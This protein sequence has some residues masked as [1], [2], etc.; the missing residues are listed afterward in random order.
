MFIPNTNGPLCELFKL[1]VKVKNYGVKRV[2]IEK[3]PR[4]R[5]YLQATVAYLIC[6]S[7][8]VNVFC[9]LNL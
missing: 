3:N 6:H 2:M 7:L 9:T 4:V 1:C 8:Q 5:F